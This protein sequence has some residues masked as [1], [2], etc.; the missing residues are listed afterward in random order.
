M[1]KK[2]H[3]LRVIERDGWDDGVMRGGK[4]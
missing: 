4:R 3:T 2:W 1:G